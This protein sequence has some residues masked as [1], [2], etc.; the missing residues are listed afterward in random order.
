MSTIWSFKNNILLKHR[1]FRTKWRLSGPFFFYIQIRLTLKWMPMRNEVVVSTSWGFHT[2][3]NFIFHVAFFFLLL[4]FGNWP[5][6]KQSHSAKF[7]ITNNPKGL[8]LSIRRRHEVQWLRFAGVNCPNRKSHDFR[9]TCA[10]CHA[11]YGFTSYQMSK[12]FWKTV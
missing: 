7:M 9:E 12:Q 5:S 10:M 3:I 1:T 6:N 2:L 8:S 4:I 11:C